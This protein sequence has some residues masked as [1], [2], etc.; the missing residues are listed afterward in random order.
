MGR[1]RELSSRAIKTQIETDIGH[2]I[3]I[4]QARVKSNEQGTEWYL[5][6]GKITNSRRY[7]AEQAKEINRLMQLARN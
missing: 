2:D 5:P 6:G 4:G 1:N 3:I 7:A